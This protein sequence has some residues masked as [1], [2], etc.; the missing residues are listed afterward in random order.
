MAEPEARKVHPGVMALAR[1]TGFSSSYVS[2]LRQA[3]KSSDEIRQYAVEQGRMTR[4]AYDKIVKREKSETQPPEPQEPAP[5]EHQPD[6]LDAA[7]E[8]HE[9]NRT[10]SEMRALKEKALW[11]KTELANA[12]ARGELLPVAVVIPSLARGLAEFRDSILCA[13]GELADRLALET[14]PAQI[15]IIMDERLRQS[16]RILERLKE[17]WEQPLSNHA[18][19]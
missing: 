1:E 6:A 10:L 9:S 5:Q 12:V 14:D 3:G 18:A 7:I 16:L 19:A 17:E 15:R 11:E 2:N 4:A 13:P 8:L